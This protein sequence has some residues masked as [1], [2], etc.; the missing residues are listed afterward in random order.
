MHVRMD[1][2]NGLLKK[3]WRLGRRVLLGML[4]LQAGIAGLSAGAA[5]FIEAPGI[6][7][8]GFSL[9]LL[10]HFILLPVFLLEL[11]TVEGKNQL[12]LYNARPAPMILGAKLLM[13]GWMYLLSLLFAVFLFWGALAL[14][15]DVLS[16]HLPVEIATASVIVMSLFLMSKVSFFIAIV[17][18]LSWTVYHALSGKRQL[19]PYRGAIVCLLFLGWW[20]AVGWLKETKVYQ[21]A[22]GIWEIPF[23]SLNQ[24]TMT[25]S[26]VSFNGE[27]LDFSLIGF[28]LEL[29]IYALLFAAACRIFD[30][31]LEV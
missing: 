22:A 27:L 5:F 17:C 30:R 10:V 26:D 19:K 1:G 13:A 20:L 21:A 24:F 23:T 9:V 28:G 7:Y 11:L 4:A 16:A 14:Y 18:L 2:L 25:A 31:K 3:D 6:I 29:I 12:W 8:I 15:K